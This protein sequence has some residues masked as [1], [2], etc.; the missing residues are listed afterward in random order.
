MRQSITSECIKTKVNGVVF[1]KNCLTKNHFLKIVVHCDDI[2]QL[3]LYSGVSQYEPKDWRLIIDSSELSL[4][5][6]LLHNV[7]QFVS[8]PIAHSIT[9]KKYKTVKYVLKKLCYDQPK[10]IVYVV[11]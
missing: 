5:C 8:V 10:W 1:V 11:L 6:V 9:L 4:K 7:T 2:A 3:L